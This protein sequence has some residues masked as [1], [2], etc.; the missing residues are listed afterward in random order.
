MA[1]MTIDTVPLVT[2]DLKRG[3][4]NLILVV[5]LVLVG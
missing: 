3:E 5:C 4:F 2:K 1:K